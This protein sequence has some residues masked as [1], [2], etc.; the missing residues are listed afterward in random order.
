M[1]AD[2]T[3]QADVEADESDSSPDI[4]LDA[5]MWATVLGLIAVGI[6][7]TAIPEILWVANGT[8]APWVTWPL[9]VVGLI[10][11]LV[12]CF[13]V[14]IAGLDDIESIPG[15]AAGK[16]RFFLINIVLLAVSLW[17]AIPAL[18]WRWPLLALALAAA[19]N[20][21][22]A[23]F[24]L[25]T[26]FREARSAENLK[27][28]KRRLRNRIR[29]HPRLYAAFL[30]LLFAGAVVCGYLAIASRV[31]LA[32]RCAEATASFLMLAKFFRV[33]NQSRLAR[34]N[35][36]DH[37]LNASGMS[38]LEDTR[39]QLQ[40]TQESLDVLTRKMA[41]SIR[42][43]NELM[44]STAKLEQEAH[45]WRHMATIA[46]AQ[47]TALTSRLRK[48]GNKGVLWNFVFF[49]AGL[50][51]SASLT[52]WP[53]IAAFAEGVLSALGLTGS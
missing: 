52:F 48:E 40:S 50:A 38:Y 7:L 3:D 22:R 29:Q 18:E 10:L 25:V 28:S 39:R 15:A 2:S 47:A 44:V 27:A 20:I 17:V 14:F 32:I 19:V 36:W 33:A 12:G 45:E 6:V 53:K 30:V 41:G 31:D 37:D 23:L 34:R 5:G 24:T 13:G 4:S 49:L 35:P 43:L 26:D 9:H 16:V 8:N 51:V 1:L 11:V 42:Q 46:E 21:V